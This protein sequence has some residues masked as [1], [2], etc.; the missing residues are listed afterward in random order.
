MVS[1]EDIKD[2]NF[3]LKRSDNFEKISLQIIK[4]L[5]M[6]NQRAEMNQR[7]ILMLSIRQF[8]DLQKKNLLNYSTLT[9]LLDDLEHNLYAVN[10][11]RKVA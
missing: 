2:L 8:E 6:Y 4:T 11:M 5:F 10:S 1:Y 7:Q 9:K 3:L